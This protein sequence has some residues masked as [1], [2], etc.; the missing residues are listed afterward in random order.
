MESLLRD[1]ILRYTPLLQAAFFIRLRSVFSQL[2]LCQVPWPVHAH[3]RLE[4]ARTAI[5]TWMDIDE[6]SSFEFD[7]SSPPARRAG[8]RLERVRGPAG[9]RGQGGRRGGGRPSRPARRLRSPVHTDHCVRVH[10]RVGL[11]VCGVAV[12]RV[13]PV[14][15]RSG[16]PVRAWRAVGVTGGRGRAQRHTTDV[17]YGIHRT[18][19]DMPK[20][21]LAGLWQSRHESRSLPRPPGNRTT[22]T[23]RNS[24]LDGDRGRGRTAR[25]T[26]MPKR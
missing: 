17:R 4:R 26:P 14:T 8:A 5:E 25:Q 13:R 2:C 10:G 23:R 3:T 21:V 19:C 6:S 9:A 24:R 15:V 18:R 11:G 12:G 7:R 1:I 20:R 16:A 22:S